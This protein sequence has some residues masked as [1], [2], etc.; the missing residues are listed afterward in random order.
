MMVGR[1]LGGRGLLVPGSMVGRRGAVAVQTRLSGGHAVDP[2]NVTKVTPYE[3]DLMKVHQKVMTNPTLRSS[4]DAR[5][6]KLKWKRNIPVH[7]NTLHRNFDDIKHSTLTER[8]ALREAIRCLRCADAPCQKS[9]PTSIDVKAFISCIANQNYYKAAQMILSDNPVGLTC[10][11]VC[12]VSDLCVGSCNLAA[13]EEG[14]INIHGLQQFAVERFFEMNI[15]ATEGEKYHIAG[16]A[17]NR[18]IALVGAGPASISCATFLARMGYKDVTIYERNHFPGGL[19]ATEIPGYRLSMNA[20]LQEV[21]IM[22]DLGVKI[23]FGMSLGQDFTVESLRADGYDAVF[24]GIGLPKAKIDKV[25]AASPP[26]FHTSKSFL[27][28]V[29][30]ASKSCG[31]CSVGCDPDPKEAE[32]P[33]LSGNVVVLGAGDTAFDCATSAFRCGAKTVTMVFRQGFGQIRAVPEETELARDEQCEFLPF[34]ISKEVVTNDGGHV[35]GLRLV[36]TKFDENGK[37]VETGDHFTLDCDHIISAFGSEIDDAAAAAVKPMGLNQWGKLDVAPNTMQS[38]STPWAFA[39]GDSAGS[40]ITVEAANDGKTAAW[41]MHAYLQSEA[42]KGQPSG[43]EVGPPR[44]PM[45]HTAVDDIDVSVEMAGIKFPNPFGLASAPPCTSGSMIRRAFE[46]GWGFAVTKTFCVDRDLITNVSPRIVRGST[47]GPL[48][49]P[50]QS[51]FMN[52]ELITEKTLAYWVKVVEELRADFPDHPIIASIM[53]SYTK[54]DWQELVAKTLPSNPHAIELNLSCPHGMGERGMGQACGQNADMVH[55]ICSW[56]REAVGPEYPFFAKLTPSVTDIR[57]IAEA[58]VA[59]GA[60]GVTAINTVSSLQ[61]IDSNG[62]PWPRVGSENLT[63]YGG[64]SGNATRPMALKA[65]SSIAASL[66][67]VPIMGTGGADSADSSRQMI[68]AG[69]SVVQICSSIQNED[70]SVIQD[71]ISG[72][73][74]HLYAQSRPDLRQWVGQTPPDAHASVARVKDHNLP[75]FGGYEVLRRKKRTEQAASESFSQSHAT[76]GN[77]GAPPPASSPDR[78]PATVNEEIGRG[79]QFISNFTDMSIEEQV[80]AVVNPETCINCG[81]CYLGCNDSGYQAIEFDEDTHIP[82]VNDNCTGCTICA[83]V[84]PVIDC[85]TMQPREEIFPESPFMPHRG[86]EPEGEVVGTLAGQRDKRV[87]DYAPVKPGKAK[88]AKVD[89]SDVEIQSKH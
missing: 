60:T 73:Q 78:A 1:V 30:Y 28:D 39:G 20:V 74:W 80:V 13:T 10:G 69:A 67:D 3:V 72:L 51:S 27:P 66:P 17:K 41:H 88:K 61:H 16:D 26:G 64:M 24:V 15:P 36:K 14:P 79:L 57:A 31:S 85:I 32:L 89:V 5:N 19:S 43:I 4:T 59:G 33:K 86:I 52:I 35:S 7:G 50:N 76:I 23:K 18:R 87:N 2:N 84:C 53:A 42:R 81:R 44:L 65:I 8:G 45:M 34:A 25:F 58:A 75:H 46:Q 55:D 63:T 68:H 82:M 37:L 22:Q 9:C 47:N 21:K 48:Y 6:E 56:V 83:S 29:N 54:E 38:S 70:F 49:G 77:R 71:Y 11:M 40:T 62:L 12:P